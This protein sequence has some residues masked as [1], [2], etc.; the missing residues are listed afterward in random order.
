MT[1]FEWRCGGELDEDVW[2][3]ESTEGKEVEGFY[4]SWSS[5]AY[6]SSCLI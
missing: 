6:A 4:T 1:G 5:A 3:K 2:G